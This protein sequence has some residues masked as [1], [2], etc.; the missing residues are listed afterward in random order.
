MSAHQKK[1]DLV[2]IGATGYTGQ[3]AA[4]H[5]SQYG[6]RNLKWAIAGRSESKLSAVIESLS[7]KPRALVTEPTRDQGAPRP[8][9]EVVG[10]F[11]ANPRR[12]DD[13]VKQTVLVVA[14]V[15]P[16]HWYGENVVKACAT[17]GVHYVD[18]CV[19]SRKTIIWGWFLLIPN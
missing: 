13:L 2:L 12:L 1:Y 19:L 5:I 15:G 4:Q 3:K 18:W 9:I 8:Q 6:P 10:D 16:Y 14:A 11:V 17:S 7:V